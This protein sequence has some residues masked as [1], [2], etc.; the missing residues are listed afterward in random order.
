MIMN[1]PLS[2][3][4]LQ[5]RVRRLTAFLLCIWLLTIALP[6]FYAREL[7]EMLPG[8][9]LHY[10]ISAQGALLVFLALVVIHA[11]L[12]NRWE[13]CVQPQSPLPASSLD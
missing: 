5:T 4:Q 10:W 3:A 7:S 2:T 6:A 12:V 8:W 9:P 13:A 11:L 1:N